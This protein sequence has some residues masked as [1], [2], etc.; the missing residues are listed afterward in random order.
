MLFVKSFFDNHWTTKDIEG[1]M[2]V[3]TKI[4]TSKKVIKK[5]KMK[6]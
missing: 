4:K 2:S 1:N 6:L 3:G 5:T